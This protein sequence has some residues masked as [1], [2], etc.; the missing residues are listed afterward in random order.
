M[1]D[2]IKKP[3]AK[4]SPLDHP[5]KEINRVEQSFALIKEMNSLEKMELSEKLKA[6]FKVGETVAA[7][8]SATPTSEKT[9][10]KGGNVSVKVVKI[11][12]TGMEKIE[13]YKM[14]KNFVNEL[15]GEVISPVQAKKRAEEGEKIILSGIPLEKAKNIE[16]ELSK[17]KVEV[18][19]K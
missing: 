17:K 2:E 9:E 3:L 5:I 1:S 18:E 4:N 13:V 11:E 8:Q 15:Q 14:I 16:K 7:P 10:E 12:A 6:E 19:I